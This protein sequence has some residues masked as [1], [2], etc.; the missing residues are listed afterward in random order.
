MSIKIMSL[1]WNVQ[2]PPSEKLVL[3]ALAD[4]AND[5]GECF[6]SIATISR[7]ASIDE[8]RTYRILKSL[9]SA[10]Q[11][12]R[13]S[14]PG[15]S[16]LYKV[17]PT[18]GIYATPGTGTTPGTYDMPPLAPVPATPGTCA[19][20]N[21][22]LTTKEPSR[23]A[24]SGELDSIDKALFAEARKVFGQSIGGKINQAIREKGK[25]WV[26][27]MIEKC[28]NKDPEAARAY[29]AAALQERSRGV[30]V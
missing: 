20:H 4:N 26:L 9:E 22:H 13:V 27:D 2:L 6:P 16:T 28:R 3:L 10:N 7:R 21:L 5:E 24:A 29:L 18:P 30:V 17:H 15:R 25:T 14:R 1:A 8:R 23:R 12:T 19:T 11:I